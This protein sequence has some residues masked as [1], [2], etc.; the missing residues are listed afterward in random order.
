MHAPRRTTALALVTALSLAACKSKVA[1]PTDAAPAKPGAPAASSSSSS[2]SAGPAKPGAATPSP[3]APKAAPAAPK[4]A[5]VAAPVAAPAPVAA[6][7]AGGTEDIVR[8]RSV[9]EQHRAHLVQ[10]F[11]QLG[12][13]AFADS[14]LEDAQ[15]HFGSVLDLDPK[16]DNARR[17]MDQI[18]AAL[19]TGTTGARST[20]DAA[21]DASRVRADQARVEV[22][23]LVAQASMKEK[24]G[25]F[26]A[27]VDL[28]DKAI[29]IETLYP[30]NVAFSPDVKG[31]EAMK[32]KAKSTASANAEADR[33]RKARVIEEKVRAEAMQQR[34]ARENRLNKLLAA[35]NRA[36]EQSQYQHAHNLAN[37]I[38]AI[39][40]Q[41]TIARRLRTLSLNAANDAAD[42]Q[43]RALWI[44]EWKHTFG[45]LDAAAMPQVD[46]Y[47]FPED[48]S[49][50]QGLRTAPSLTDAA[51]GGEDP[52][53]RDVANRLDGQRTSANFDNTKLADAVAFLSRISGANI[54]I[55]PAATEGKSEEDLTIQ[56]LKLE[57]PLPVAQILNLVT[58]VTG[59]AWNVENGV[60]Q[61]T[62]QEAARG[63]L[64][65]QLYDVKDIATPI[66]NFPGEEINLD[67]TGDLTTAEEAPEAQPE[68]ALDSI[69]EL[70]TQ[71]VDKTV[72]ENGGTVETVPPGTLVVKAP[73]DTQGRVSQLLSGLRGAGGLQVS[74]E[75]R[76]VTVTDNF[77][78]DIGVDLRGL[79]DQSGGLGIAGKGGVPIP[80]GGGVTPVTFDDVFFGSAGA[81]QG[82]GSGN[83]VGVFYNMN[84]DGD[85]RARFENLYDVALGK[86]GVLTPLGGL[87]FQGTMIDDTQLEVILRAV[88]KND[89]STLVM[90]PRLTAY[91]GQRA[92]I[93]VLNQISYISDFDVEIAQA[94]QIGD[95]IVQTL[96]DGVI[97]DLRPTVTADRRFI[98][99]ELRPTVAIITRP[100][101]TFQTTLANGPPVTIQLPELQVQRVRTTVTMPDGGTLLLGGLKFFEERRLE[102]SVPWFDKVPVLNFVLSRKGTYTERKNV[103][104][105]IR[106][107][108]VR[109]EENE[110]AA[111][112]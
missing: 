54:V 87:S 1:A 14:R 37:E 13:S 61:I 62:T 6:K 49:T 57:N 55:L 5:P 18:G 82:I 80:G 2:S 34:A 43:L 99:M 46:D 110:P 33:A 79:G 68:Y 22:A 59:L 42:Q 92:N 36:M 71:N 96:R 83:D 109:P 32:A 93:T 81:P 15:K 77:L 98:T 91:N 85:L 45:Q 47:S 25:D 66:P 88:E 4:P 44:D 40:G 3:A 51:S 84:S 48:W 95:P 65:V 11:T 76:F 8:D 17:R 27:A 50:N 9:R 53:D 86:S 73:R 70:I 90:A 97:L 29:L 75:T 111:V 94:A 67:P 74:I 108:I 72:W 19:G 56:S 58:K 112:R 7:P 41:H 89:R 52:R 31:L 106:A 103:L 24:V 78:Q 12:E 102:S 39:D 101:A 107:R 21:R 105:L 100:L 64:V 16:N 69:A 23:N 28:Y 30:G 10:Q 20:F 26:E 104:V 60:V 35:A 63:A 38:L